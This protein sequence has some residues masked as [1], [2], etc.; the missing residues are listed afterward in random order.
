[1]KLTCLGSSSKGNGYVLDNGKEALVLE[2]GLPL[3]EASKAVGCEVSRI[4]AILVSHRHGDH[5]KYLKEYINAGIPVYCPSDVYGEDERKMVYNVSFMKKMSAGGFVFIPVEMVHD[6]P[7]YGYLIKHAD[8]GQLLFA[9]DT[10]Y[11][12]GRFP[13]VN[14]IMVEA[15]YSTEILH[16]R[17]VCGL[18]EKDRADRIILNHQSIDTCCEF[19]R[20]TC[21]ENVVN[22]I[23]LHLSEDNANPEEFAREASEESMRTAIVARKG[24]EVELLPDTTF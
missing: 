8:M 15:N 3:S 21:N 16:R 17:Q 14:H 20:R 18:V 9:T 11:I 24:V 5:A 23:L 10:A 1:M 13:S 19:L 4:A 22:V 6:V 7:C 12:R 2:A